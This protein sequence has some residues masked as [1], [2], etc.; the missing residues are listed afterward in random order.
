MQTI[1]VQPFQY[2]VQEGI[3]SLSFVISGLSSN[4]LL[5]LQ[6][7]VVLTLNPKDANASRDGWVP[8]R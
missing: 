6:L 7:L 3:G 1:Y 4:P 5:K 8:P 2:F